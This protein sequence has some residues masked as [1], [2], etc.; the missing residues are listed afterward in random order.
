MRTIEDLFDAA[1]RGRRFNLVLIAA[2]GVAALGLAVLGTYGLTSYLVAQRTREIG[3]R[4]ALGAERSSVVR[5]VAGHGAR[6]AMTGMAI[7]LG[8]S[9]LLT[10][11]VRGFLFA[12]SP[13]D[14]LS[15]AAVA[16]VTA[17]AVVLASLVPAWRAARI[18]PTET[19]RS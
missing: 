4:L 19:L 15:L 10:G 9:L 3:I 6:L 13:A 18:S 2:F 17:V 16:A 11:V 14:P 1:L 8:A 7:G 5:L 12:I